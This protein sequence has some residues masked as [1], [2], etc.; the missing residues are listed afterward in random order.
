MSL[1]NDYRDRV[2]EA[3][4]ALATAATAIVTAPPVEPVSLE[5]AKAQV[6]RGD[7][8]FDDDTLT[9]LIKAARE[10]VEEDTGRALITQTHDLVMDAPPC[11]GLLFLPKPPL[12]S[13]T[14]VTTY[15]ADDAAT[16]LAG[17]SYIV[18]AA[19]TP[20]RLTVKSTVSWP[21]HTLRDAKGLIVQFVCGYGAAGEDVPEPLR[22]AMLLLIGGFFEHREHVIV[23]QFAGQFIELPKGYRSLIGPYKVGA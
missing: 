8:T 2:G 16:V 4:R 14:S 6:R 3:Y 12:Q 10:K 15:D 7:A 11:G 17:S 21:T 22:Q 20:G 18:N 13:V 1:F 5:Q 23:A 9:R 19:A